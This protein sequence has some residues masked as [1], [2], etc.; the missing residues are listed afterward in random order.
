MGTTYV[1]LSP[2][3]RTAAGCLRDDYRTNSALFGPS[4]VSHPEVVILLSLLY[5]YCGG[6]AEENPIHQP[7]LFIKSDWSDFHTTNNCYSQLRPAISSECP[8]KIPTN[9]SS[10]CFR[11][12]ATSRRPS[13]TTSSCYQVTRQAIMEGITLPHTQVSIHYS[14]STRLSQRS[15]L[16]SPHLVGP[17]LISTLPRRHWHLRLRSISVRVLSII[18]FTS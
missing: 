7:G 1:A 14:P 10:S 6:V 11:F 17:T 5:H 12:D 18:Q 8:S 15:M 9:T 4:G 2:S 16:I 13:T 3:S